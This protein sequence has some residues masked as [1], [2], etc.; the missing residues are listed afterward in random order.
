MLFRSVTSVGSD[1]FTATTARGESV[2]V[3]IT[4]ATRFGT[5]ARPFTRAQLVPGAEVF[6]RLRKETDGTVVATVI[7][8]TTATQSTEPSA[9]ASSAGT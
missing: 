5:A 1:S 9:T 8:S 2:V 4:S 6:A 3:H 7:A